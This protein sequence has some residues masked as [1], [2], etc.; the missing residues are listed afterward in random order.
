MSGRVS[1]ALLAGLDDRESWC[2]LAQRAESIGF[3]ALLASDHVG[4]TASAWVSLAAAAMVTERIALGPCVANA[5]VRDPVQ[6][7]CDAA[8]LELLA[9]GRCELGL[10]AGHTPREWEAAGKAYPVAGRRVQRLTEVAQVVQRILLGETVTFK[11]ATV[12][13]KEACLD[14]E[15]IPARRIPLR[16]GGNGPKLLRFAAEHADIVSVTGLGATRSDGHSHDVLWDEADIDRRFDLI[17]ETATEAGRE[18]LLEV[19]VQ[20]TEVT[21]DR[22]AAAQILIEQIRAIAGDVRG[23]TPATALGSPFTLIGTPQEIAA[24]IAENNARWGIARYVL[25]TP[26]VEHATAIITATTPRSALP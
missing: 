17:R 26:A 10:G 3:E 22:E 4:S 18:P 11:G 6:I 19:L 2:A 24:Q 13:V 15:L 23:L 14:R 16:I 25:R 12:T 9:P 7:A 1:F 5:G 20:H 8:T 21:S